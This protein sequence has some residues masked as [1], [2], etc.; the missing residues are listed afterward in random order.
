MSEYHNV[1]VI[2]LNHRWWKQSVEGS[3]RFIHVSLAK[4]ESAHSWFH[5]HYISLSTA[6]AA[7]TLYIIIAGW[8]ELLLSVPCLSYFLSL[9]IPSFSVS[10]PVSL[11]GLTTTVYSNTSGCSEPMGMKSR[12]VSN[13]QITASSTFRTWGIEAFTWHPHYARLDKQGKTNAWTAATNNRSE[14]LQVGQKGI[15]GQDTVTVL[16]SRCCVS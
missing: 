8:P 1:G 3:E 6:S 16:F 4:P 9:S 10:S 14:W 15:V 7:L 13:R 11:S 2:S 12:L 5:L